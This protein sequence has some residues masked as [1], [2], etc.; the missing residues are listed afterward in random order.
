[1]ASSLSKGLW[2][3]WFCTTDRASGRKSHHGLSKATPF[4]ASVLDASACNKRC[5]PEATKLPPAESPITT[6][7]SPLSTQC[8]K[9]AKTSSW[10]WGKGCSGA[11]R[12][13]G[14]TT[15]HCVTSPSG[16]QPHD[17]PEGCQRRRRHRESKPRF[18][19]QAFPGHDGT[20]PSFGSDDLK[21]PSPM[22]PGSTATPSQWPNESAGALHAP[23]PDEANAPHGGR[24]SA[25]LGGTANR[26]ASGKI[27]GTV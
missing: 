5:N 16:W 24:W 9:A 6:R 23:H 10:A 21:L 22:V 20:S 8:A 7:E 15:L 18:L 12:Y 14:S 26:Q 1:M 25:T 2:S 4:S 11:S 3:I 19:R 17:T 13:D 27:A